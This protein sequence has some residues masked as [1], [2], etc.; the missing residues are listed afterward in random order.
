[1]KKIL[2]FGGSGMVG[3]RFLGLY[4]DKFEINAPNMEEVDILNKTSVTK[5]FADFCP[6]A[7]INFA[8]Y[9]NVEEAEKQNG[10]KDSICYM[11]NVIGVKN[12]AEVSKKNGV[13]LVHIST[14]YVFN[15]EKSESPYTEGDMP[16]AIN[17]YGKTKQMADETILGSGCSFTI[18]RIS[19]PYCID[20]PIKKDVA[21]FFLNQLKQGLKV[22]AID[23]QKITPTFTDDLANAF[24]L[25][26]KKSPRGIY[27]LSVTDYITPFEFAK[28]I[29]LE[30]GFDPDLI[31]RVSFDEYNNKK[32]AKLLKYSWLD[33]SKFV[34]EFGSG[35]FHL[36]DE[37]IK[38]FKKGVDALNLFS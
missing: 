26:V 14:E 20:Y 17:W 36:V 6:D 11:I 38:G 7:V 16:G 28:K 25:I 8:A 30:F 34:K 18:A 33:S 13:H 3:S 1:M 19:M 5:I 27:N 2:I 15:G 31:D 35:I 9:T 12:I 24:A 21:R 29:A 32:T 37:N 23:G 10:D 4:K 22:Y